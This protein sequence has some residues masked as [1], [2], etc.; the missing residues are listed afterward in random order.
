MVVYTIVNDLERQKF[1]KEYGIPFGYGYTPVFKGSNGF[2]EAIE[3]LKDVKS[4]M[5]FVI[6][7]HENGKIE[8]VSR[9]GEEFI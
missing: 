1:E 4:R 6:E 5:S 3:F 8:L 7:R 9:G 2:K